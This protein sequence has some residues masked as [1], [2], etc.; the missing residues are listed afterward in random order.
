MTDRRFHDGDTFEIAP[1]QYRLRPGRKGPDDLVLEWR[2][3]TD[4]R[5]VEL[6]HVA[7]IVDAIADN[8]NVLYPRPAAGGGMVAGFV[9]TALRSGWRK[10]R[11]DLHLQRARHDDRSYRDAG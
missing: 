8:E 11:H 9:L 3:M 10:A 1:F 2:W 5:P 7:L 6:D 4:W